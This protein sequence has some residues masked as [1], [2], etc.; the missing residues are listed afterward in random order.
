IWWLRA[1]S[2][3]CVIAGDAMLAHGD[4][5]EA[6]QTFRDGLARAESLHQRVP[7]S[8]F[9]EVDVAELYEAMGRYCAAMAS[10]SGMSPA[11]RAELRN[12][13]RSWFG[14]SLAIWQDWSKRHMAAPFAA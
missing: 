2:R 12:Q 7:A 5:D 14:R 3:T 10:R 9:H 4:H 6:L 1:L 11:K 13:A 8:L